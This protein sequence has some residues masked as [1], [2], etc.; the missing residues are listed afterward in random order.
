MPTSTTI[1]HHKVT[2]VALF[3]HAALVSFFCVCVE[4][5]LA[6]PFPILMPQSFCERPHRAKPFCAVFA[7]NTIIAEIG[8][9]RDCVQLR[10]EAMD[11]DCLIAHLADNHLSLVLCSLTFFAHLA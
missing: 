7:L 5:L 2:F 4:A 1:T 6:Q 11:V 10:G 3:A 9:A 8:M